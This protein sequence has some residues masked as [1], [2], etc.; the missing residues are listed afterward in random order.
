MLYSLYAS[1]IGFIL[2]LLF[3]DPQWMF[4]H[5]VRLIGHLISGI[6]KWIRRIFP[7]GKTGEFIGG[8]VLAIIVIAVSTMIPIGLLYACKMVSPWLALIVEGIL[9]Y[10]LFATKSLKT[11]SMKVYYALKNGTLEDGRKAVSMI[12]GRDVSS[13]SEEGV[14][15]AAVETVAENTSDGIIAPMFFMMIGGA[16]LGFFYKAINTMDS[17]I[18]YKNEKYMHFG[19]FAA[20]ADDV[21]NYIPARFS[22]FCMII[23]AAI[24]P[25]FDPVLGFKVYRR[26]RYKSASPNSAQTE[27]VCAGAMHVRLLG[28]AYY[29]GVLHKKDSI[30]EDIEPV[31]I[32][33]IKKVNWLLYGT[34][35]VG[36]LL[37]SLVKFGM[38]LA[39]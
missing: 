27:S 33:S 9:C 1:I 34:V 14:A 18:G 39:C 2:D 31:T 13:L 21:V 22:A 37:C 11:E 19:T 10:F 28:D 8:M 3:G 38:I 5:P 25:G 35:F 12:V 32:E 7:K 15:K 30:G 20:K 6:K 4:F 16:P 24:L 26:D 29:F 17:M 36:M 23:A